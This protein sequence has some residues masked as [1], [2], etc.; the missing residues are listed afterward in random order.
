[1]TETDSP[2]YH[3]ETDDVYKDREQHLALFDTFDY[4][5]IYS[6]YSEANKQNVGTFKDETNRVMTNT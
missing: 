1:M 2:I 5:P 6:S 3:I 4:P